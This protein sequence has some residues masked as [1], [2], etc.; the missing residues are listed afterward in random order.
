MWD[1][2]GLH[3][4]DIKHIPDISSS[5]DCACLCKEEPGCSFFTWVKNESFV[6]NAGSCKLKTSD[7]GR[8]SSNIRVSGTVG[9]CKGIARLYNIACDQMLNYHNIKNRI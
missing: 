5:M 8:G 2:T 9:C 3:G 6:K 7:E 4:N 1:N